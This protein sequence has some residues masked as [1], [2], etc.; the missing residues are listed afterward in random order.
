[1]PLTQEYSG[2]TSWVDLDD[3]VPLG[4]MTPAIP[5]TEYERRVSEIKAALAATHATA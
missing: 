2:C 4:K 5:D 3:E 1:M